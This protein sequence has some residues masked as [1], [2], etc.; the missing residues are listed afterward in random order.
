MW[1][2]WFG[3][4][5]GVALVG[6]PFVEI[7]VAAVTGRW[8]CLCDAV[9]AV[10]GA[11]HADMKMGVVPPPRTNFAQSLG[12]VN[13]VMLLAKVLFNNGVDEDTRGV[14]VFGGGHDRSGIGF[15]PASGDECAVGFVNH[16][17]WLDV[18]GWD[19]AFGNGVKPEVNIQSI[20]VAGVA[21]GHFAACGLAEV[22]DQ[23][24]CIVEA[25]HV[26]A[27]VV[28]YA[29]RAGLSVVAVA[30]AADADVSVACLRQYLRAKLA[31]IGV[32]ADGFAVCADRVGD[33][34]PCVAFLWVGSEGCVGHNQ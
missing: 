14:R 3:V 5:D 28:D 19:A 25:A 13:R 17:R 24:A 32:A 12:G 30:P 27:D 29:K 8:R 2:G 22:A 16:G 10:C 4:Q 23:D 34:A 20:L 1:L 6:Y 18:G 21:K 11:A 26:V 7:G 9:G 33:A 31:A 15:L